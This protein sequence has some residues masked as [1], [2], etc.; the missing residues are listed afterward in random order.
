LKGGQSAGFM[1]LN[2]VNGS[3]M[4]SLVYKS[5]RDIELKTNIDFRYD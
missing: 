1:G 2:N 4:E 5:I 3:G